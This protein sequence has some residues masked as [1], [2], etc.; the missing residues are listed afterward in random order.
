MIS[1]A[2]LG[3]AC[4]KEEDCSL[5]NGDATCDVGDTDKCICNDGSIEDQING[6][7]VGKF[8]RRKHS[9]LLW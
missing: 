5:I 3:D 7:C 6:G 1:V 2:D 4:T 9:K 8:V